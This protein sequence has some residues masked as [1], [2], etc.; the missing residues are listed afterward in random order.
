M[1]TLVFLHA[2]PDDECL[3][4][5][6]AMA[7][8]AAEGH[9]PVLVIATN[10]DH[11]EAPDDL[12]PG[13]TLIDRRR[14][15]TERSA[16]IL[17]VQRVVWLGY[18]DSGMTGWEQNSH[19]DSF[20]SAPLDEAAEKVATVLREEAAD[21]LVTYDWHGNYGH[22]DHIKVHHVGHKAAALAATPTVFEA[23]MNRDE[24]IRFMELLR[25]AAAPMPGGD[26]ETPVDEFDPNG[27]M[28]DGNPIGMSA[29]ELT[30]EVDVR[31]YVHLKRQAIA[32]HASQV[33]DTQFFLQ[34][35][36]DAFEIAF[37]SEWYI[38]ADPDDSEATGLRTGWLLE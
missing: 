36:D 22:P 18:Q 1:K 15:E 14:V 5:G 10:G 4:T 32:C 24:M 12:A 2:H 31:P 6:G 23:T 30:H 19:P 29:A 25:D 37:G 26:G 21:V 20:S 17:G 38:K 35:P 9:R 13:E 28:D 34:M 7:R 8:A 11:G 27:P 33:T 16:E 3:L